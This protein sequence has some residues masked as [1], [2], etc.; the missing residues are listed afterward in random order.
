MAAKR[1]EL[2]ALLAIKEMSHRMPTMLHDLGQ[3]V[4]SLAKEM[5]GTMAPDGSC[6]GDDAIVVHVPSGDA[7]R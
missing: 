6:C 2:A 7:C 1:E 3:T 4:T 5:T